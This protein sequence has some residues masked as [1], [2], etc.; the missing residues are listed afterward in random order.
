VIALKVERCQRQPMV[1]LSCVRKR[2]VG[3]CCKSSADLQL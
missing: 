2:L 1:M 3:M